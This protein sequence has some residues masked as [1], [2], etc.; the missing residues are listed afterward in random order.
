MTDLRRAAELRIL[1]PLRKR[2]VTAPTSCSS[3]ISPGGSQLF[4]T[5]CPAPCSSADSKNKR[6]FQSSPAQWWLGLCGAFGPPYPLKGLHSPDTPQSM[7]ARD[8]GFLSR[9]ATRHIGTRRS[10]R[11]VRSRSESVLLL[12]RKWSPRLAASS[13]PSMH[14]LSQLA[15]FNAAASERSGTAP[16]PL[17]ALPCIH[18]NVT[19]RCPANRSSIRVV[20]GA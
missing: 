5:R 10:A 16:S 19:G 4:D 2:L 15:S 8:C 12:R 17:Q 20:C 7:L 9:T 1:G 14:V 11:S 6:T 3:S 13:R 18:A